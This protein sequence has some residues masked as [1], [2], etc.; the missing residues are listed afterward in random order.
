RAGQHLI[1]APQ[2]RSARPRELEHEAVPKSRRNGWRILARGERRRLDDR[3]DG[4]DVARGV[5][6]DAHPDADLLSI[7]RVLGSTHAMHP[8][9]PELGAGVAVE[10]GYDEIVEPVDRRLQTCRDQHVAVRVERGRLIPEAVL[11]ERADSRRPQ[12]FTGFAVV[13][14]D[15]EA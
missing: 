2:L 13:L 12:D 7:A 14:V 11:V 3:A 8:A 5:G 9:P 15:D 1:R 6:G 10:L 4:E